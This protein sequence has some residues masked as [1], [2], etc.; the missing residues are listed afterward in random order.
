MIYIGVPRYI[1]VL[2]KVWTLAA[3][4]LPHFVWPLSLSHI[5]CLVLML[6]IMYV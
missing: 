4:L 5:G 6:D 2:G 1:H 3:F